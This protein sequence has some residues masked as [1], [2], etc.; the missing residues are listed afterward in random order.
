LAGTAQEHAGKGRTAAFFLPLINKSGKKSAWQGQQ[1]YYPGWDDGK[2]Q[3]FH[4]V[5]SKRIFIDL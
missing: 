2:K 4:I 5:L 1:K 3:G